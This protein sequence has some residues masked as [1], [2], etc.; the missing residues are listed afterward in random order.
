MRAVRSAPA[1][2]QQIDCSTKVAMGIHRILLLSSLKTDGLK[3]PIVRSQPLLHV[4]VIVY[5]L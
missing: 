4:W 2:I 3:L 5:I 1:S